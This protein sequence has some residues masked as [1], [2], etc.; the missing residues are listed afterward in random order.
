MGQNCF[1]HPTRE[2]LS[3]CHSCG[4]HFCSQCLVEG[5]EFYYCKDQ[6]CQDMLRQ[7]TVRTE[8]QR[9]EQ[10][11]K[12]SF[13]KRVANFYIDSLII[14]LVVFL[15]LRRTGLLD[16]HMTVF[17]ILM[18]LWF[19]YYFGFEHYLRRTPGK[20]V[21]RTV[22]KCIDGSEPSTSQILKRTLSRLIPLDMYLWEDGRCLHDRISGTRVFNVKTRT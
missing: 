16:H 5:E 21:T 11:L 2:A 4:R 18:I 20:F 8:R 9:V 17:S 22:V 13:L 1:R 3:S 15:L 14:I 12:A 19:M 10:S 7:E 6:T